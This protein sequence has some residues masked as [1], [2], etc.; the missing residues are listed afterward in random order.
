[1]KKEKILSYFGLVSKTKFDQIEKLNINLQE[2]N[3]QFEYQINKLIKKPLSGID[4][5]SYE[6]WSG[7][8]Q[9]NSK[10][11]NQYWKECC[12]SVYQAWYIRKIAQNPILLKNLLKAID[13]FDWKDIKEYMDRV[14]W[15]WGYEGVPSIQDM[16][17]TIYEL[18]SNFNGESSTGGFKVKID[19]EYN[20]LITFNKNLMF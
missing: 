8:E 18:V 7:G 19:E 6:E 10:N 1:M 12:E 13:D 5:L 11:W 14:N 20:V 4:Y 16:K 2:Q 9:Y 3:Q 17:Y 15:K